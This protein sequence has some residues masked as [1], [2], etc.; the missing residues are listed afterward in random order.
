MPPALALR[1]LTTECIYHFRGFLR[2][3]RD[4]FPKPVP[5]KKWRRNAF[6]MWQKLN[7]YVL[8]AEM[9]GVAR[10]DHRTKWLS[11]VNCVV[12]NFHPP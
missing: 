6:S 4:Y 10:V 3:Y 11:L 1:I 12:E 9:P 2:I 8:L 7:Y 5:L